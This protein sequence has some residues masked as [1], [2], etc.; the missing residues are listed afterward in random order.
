MTRNARKRSK[1]NK[2]HGG[3]IRHVMGLFTAFLLGY[4]TASVLDMKSAVTW[5]NQYWPHEQSVGPEQQAVA[6]AK[7]ADIPKPKFEFY[8]LLSKNNT[9]PT[10][11]HQFAAPRQDQSAATQ[12][13]P[14]QAAI[15]PIGIPAQPLLADHPPQGAVQVAE[16]HALGTHPGS[17]SVAAGRETYMIQVA[18]V[19]RRQDAERLKSSLSAKGYSVMIISPSI[20]TASWFRVV[21]G[22][23]HN[24]ADAEKTQEMVSRNEHLQGMI[25]KLDA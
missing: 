4:L 21:I 6:V 12:P 17:T 8:T 15:E 20:N 11:V 19:T 14:T 9:A 5:I 25:R 1:G 2:Q 22:P 23:F 3:V 24:R 16:S 18:A 7:K 10:D 13:A